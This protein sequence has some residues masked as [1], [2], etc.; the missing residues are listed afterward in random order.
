VTLT[1]T[2]KNGTRP[3]TSPRTVTDT[4]SAER[5]TTTSVMPRPPTWS[6]NCRTV[7][8]PASDVPDG[9]RAASRPCCAAAV[10]TDWPWYQMAICRTVKS[11]VMRI[12]T[13][14]TLTATAPRSARMRPAAAPMPLSRRFRAR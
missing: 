1:G 11:T 13:T 7:A 14:T 3:C 5:S 4:S 9:T 10:A 8:L 12:G 6:T 2:E